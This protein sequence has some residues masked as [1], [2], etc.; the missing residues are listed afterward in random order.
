MQ[1]LIEQNASV[2]PHLLREIIQTTLSCL[3]ASNLDILKQTLNLGMQATIKC[4]EDITSTHLD[5]VIDFLE[6][7]FLTTKPTQVSAGLCCLL[8]LLRSA[9]L[10][11]IESKKNPEIGLI[12]KTF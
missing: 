7:S 12:D 6:T 4:G 10:K 1:L 8:K 9:Y 5:Y 3:K 11:N 2:V